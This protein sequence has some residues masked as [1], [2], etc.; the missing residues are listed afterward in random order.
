MV[1]CIKTGSKI[2]ENPNRTAPQSAVSSRSIRICGQTKSCALHETQIGQGSC[3]Q[4]E[5]FVIGYKPLSSMKAGR[6]NWI[7][8]RLFKHRLQHRMLE[9]EGT[10]E[11][12]D[13]LILSNTLH[14]VTSTWLDVE[15]TL[16][17]ETT[18][19]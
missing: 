14:N 8:I 10:P 9:N 5:N 13:L 19:S 18:Q 7:H 16:N 1:H 17:W 4:S 12:S 15:I 2:E 6:R 3:S 11:T